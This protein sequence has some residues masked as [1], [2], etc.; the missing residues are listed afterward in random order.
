MSTD[1]PAL[2]RAISIMSTMADQPDV[3]FRS[4]ELSE[5][6]GISKATCY[7]LLMCLVEAG[8]LERDEENKTYALGAS[9]VGLGSAASRRHAGLSE[10]ST[11]IQAMSRQLGVQCLVAAAMGDQIVVVDRALPP[12]GRV[13]SASPL[14]PRTRLAPP[15]GMVYMSWAPK[16]EFTAWLERHDVTG[17]SEQQRYLAAARVVRARGYAGGLEDNQQQLVRLLNQLPLASDPKSRQQVAAEISDI[18]QHGVN[19]ISSPVFG[20][21]GSVP[22]A[23][24]IINPSD[25]M[26]GARFEQMARQLTRTAAK[27]TK[28]MGGRAPTEICLSDT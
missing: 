14:G 9:L 28:A 21:D 22:L 16:D 15:A 2:R 5:V 25:V 20:P 7:S 27:V 12:G 6:L 1:V 23:L 8:W 3:R 18:L 19:F 10:A 24:T 4:S 17:R 26:V 11:A 13:P